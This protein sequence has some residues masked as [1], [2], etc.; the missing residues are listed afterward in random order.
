MQADTE[1]V[2]TKQADSHKTVGT[3]LFEG[4]EL[5][6]V[7]GPLEAYGIVPEHFKLVI[8][9]EKAGLV[10]SHQGPKASAEFGFDD[11]PHMDILL[12]PGGMG[13]RRERSNPSML[14]FLKQRAAQA[15]FATSVCSGA[16]LYAGAG[17]LDGKRATTNK[18]HYKELTG[19]S[20]KVNWV[21]A[22][23][24]VQ[25]GKFITSSGVSAGIDMTLDVIAHIAGRETANK[26]AIG[27]EYEWHTDPHWDP[28]A[29]I[30][31]L[32]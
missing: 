1:I 25:D 19:Y 31:E 17:L 15:Q 26:A 12:V 2:M 9:A 32:V 29:R 11:C 28:F 5:L 21:A 8:V 10:A 16:I 30:H 20:P 23:R 13:T 24:W 27:M 18:L 14:E 22:A 3:V 7:F 4:F 6:D